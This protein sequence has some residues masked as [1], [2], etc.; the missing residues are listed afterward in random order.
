MTDLKSLLGNH[1]S[2][3]LK[4]GQRIGV[5]TG[6]TVSAVLSSLASSIKQNNLKV[7]FLPTSYQSASTCSQYG[8]TVVDP[9]SFQGKLDWAFDG[10]DEVDP[11]LRLI[12]GKGGA[13]LREKIVA[14]R[15]LEF[16]VIVDESKLVS[17]LGERTAVPVEIIPESLP[18]V[19]ETLLSIG[20]SK[21]LLR[22]GLPGK[23][24]PI[25]TERGN[26]VLDASFSPIDDEL[27]SKI[28]LI[29]GVVESGLFTNQATSVLVSSPTGV[30]I[31][32]RP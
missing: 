20:A 2:Q 22:D 24:G 13:M 31:L 14:S 17:S 21:V 15:A 26:L 29:P 25:I 9:L 32:T 16:T 1:L 10:A 6:S 28:K 12:K 11:T 3:Y 19:Q 30:K 5:G 18:T 23:H 27:E 8:L 7:T 4:D